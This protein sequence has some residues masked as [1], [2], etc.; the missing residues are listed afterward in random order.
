MIAFW[1]VFTPKSELRWRDALVWP[2]IVAAYG[3]FA[4]VFGGLT[5]QYRYFF[6]DAGT[7]GWAEVAR[8]SL[9]LLAI[10]GAMG[11]LMIAVGR[12]DKRRGG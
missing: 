10:F 11:A 4:L 9:T 12:L 3:V 6:L 8:N 1:F 7:L 5:G 2:W